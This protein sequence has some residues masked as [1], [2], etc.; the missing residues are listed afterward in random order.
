MNLQKLFLLTE[1]NP[2]AIDSLCA[3]EGMDPV[4]SHGVVMLMIAN[5]GNIASLSAT[6]R[7]HYD[8][9]ILPLIS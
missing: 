6:Q 8:K 1:E 5:D 9:T 3:R 2:Q 7:E 4:V